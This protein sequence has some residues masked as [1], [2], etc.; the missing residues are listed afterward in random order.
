M[1]AVMSIY[2]SFLFGEAEA[3]ELQAKDLGPYAK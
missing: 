1:V 3:G 2:G